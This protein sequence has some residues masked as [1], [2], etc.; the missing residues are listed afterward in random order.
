M[1]DLLNC[2]CGYR[3]WR[4]LDCVLCGLPAASLLADAEVIA[5]VLEL[6]SA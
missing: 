2:R 4:G 1:H 3:V 6:R 5:E